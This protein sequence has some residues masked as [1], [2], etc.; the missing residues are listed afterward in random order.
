MQLLNSCWQA[1]TAVELA[2]PCEAFRLAFGAA[3]KAVPYSLLAAALEALEATK[4]RL[5]KETILTNAFR[6]M[7]AN[8]VSV[9]EVEAACYLLA[10]GKDAQQGG[11]RLR[12]DWVSE[13]PLSIGY[14]AISAA[15]M[16]AT[17]ASQVEMKRLSH[18]LHDMGLVAFKLHNSGGRQRLLKKPQ[19]LTARL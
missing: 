17:G 4:S 18:E 1:A 5:K 13:K 7:M 6:L 9:E 15:L 10:P 19:P 12:P 14:K 3:S 8:N 16:E 2:K 11:H